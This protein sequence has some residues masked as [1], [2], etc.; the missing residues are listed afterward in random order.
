MA[1]NKCAIG[2]D[3]YR[4]LQKPEDSVEELGLPFYYTGPGNK[5]DLPAWWQAASPDGPSR[6]SRGGILGST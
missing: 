2:W 4:N 5:A 6:W 1:N 3:F